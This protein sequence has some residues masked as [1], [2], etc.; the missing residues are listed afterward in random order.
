[1]R[2]LFRGY[3]KPTPEE[4]VEIWENC[5]FSFDA[6]VLLH[7]YCYTPETR[8][9]FFEI[10]NR[11]KERIWIPY[12]VA[13]EYQK[14]RIYVISKYFKA[15]EEIEK[16]LNK[17][18][19]ELKS[20]LLL[21]YKQ[22]PVI[23][24]QEILETFENVIG[25]VIYQL[26][27]AKNSHPNYLEH[28]KL[29]EVL[30]DLLDGKVGQPYTEE[31]LENLYQK[32]EKRFTYQKP[33]GYKDANKPVPRSY[34]D[35]ILWFQLIDYA[36]VQQK[37]IIFVTD[38]NKE[39]WWLKYAGES[40]EP[41]P[42][43]I[44]EILSEVG[45]EKFQFYMYHSDQFLDYAEKFLGLPGQPEVIKEAREIML[46][47]SVNKR[48]AVESQ[49][50]RSVGYDSSNQVLEIE[51]QKGE[52]YHY[53]DVPATVYAGLMNAASHGKYFNANIKDVYPYH[54]LS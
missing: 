39:D 10:L 19:Q 51:F 28:D 33:P 24:I 36:K 23:N 26:N 52:V 31:E 32:A 40:L 9:R 1:M 21:E 54:K 42:D 34:G 7:I 48:I 30:S 14:N 6:N 46:Q 8:E 45:G 17:K 15:Y 37:S 35:V 47:S 12:Q 22:H 43:L 49:Y 38:D 50:L 16:L 27:E 4:L 53:Q 2:N 18:N 44:Q 20:E 29:R 25:K 3:Y 5:I 13:Y 41:R 11:L